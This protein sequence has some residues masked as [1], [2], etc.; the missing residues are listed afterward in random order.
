MNF[1]S[2]FTFTLDPIRRLLLINITND[3]D[4]V[5]I[6]FEPQVFDDPI[7]GRG[8][9]VI[10]YLKDGRIDVYHQP[11][12]SLA[13]KDYNIVG[14]GLREQAERPM[15]GA[16]FDI[17][18]KGIDLDVAFDDLLGRPVV[19][20]IHEA[21]GKPTRP[22]A[23]LAPM[24]NTVERPPALPLFFLYDFYFVRRAGTELLIS[25]DGRAYEPDSI[26]MIL[27]GSRVYFLRYAAMPFLI[28][29][30]A[31][32]DGILPVIE[33]GATG[34]PVTYEWSEEGERPALVVMSIAHMDQTVAFRFDPPFPDVVTLPD[35]ARLAGSLVIDAGIGGTVDGT[36][37]VERSGDQVEITLNP[38]GGWAPG[39]VQWGARL[40]FTLV[41]LFRKWP[42]TYLWRGR[43]DLSGEQ[44]RLVSAW[45]RSA[46]A[47]QGAV[48]LFGK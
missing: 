4:E 26:P 37:H 9:A 40:I 23:I 39:P 17:T 47:G 38:S 28:N 22:F 1:H 24:G 15:T 27:D 2:P 48:K 43:V 31:A 16:H 11:D 32:Y 10:A 20:R 25:V 33:T 29:W 35:N 5:Y 44:P 42:Q 19:L 36:Y 14:K 18:L 7:N 13:G 8:L 34:G 3:P 46:Q 45:E 21:G 12:V 6:G 41:P 30:N